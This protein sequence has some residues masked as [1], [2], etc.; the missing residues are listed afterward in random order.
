MKNRSKKVRTEPSAL[1]NNGGFITAAASLGSILAGL[2]V[3][4][5]IT[6]VVSF[7]SDTISLK[8]GLEG[9]K[10]IFFG[11]F[12]TGRDA[13]GELSFGF[14]PVN[15]GNL[16]F[17][18]TPVIMTGLSV[19][20]SFRAGLFNI[21]APGQYLMGTAATLFVALSLP[22]EAV[23]S[24]LIWLLSFLSGMLAG[25][26]WGAIPGLLKARLNI[27]EVLSG[28]MT[29]WIAANLVTWFFENSSLR[30]S[31]Q[32]G[33]IGYVMPTSLNGV[34]TSKIGLDKL[35]P[36]SQVNGGIIVALLFAFI[37]YTMLYK[38][39]SGY[40]M[41]A[42][43][44]NRFAAEYAGMK[45]K[46]VTVLSMAAAGALS[47]GGA[48]LYYLSGNTEFF[49]STY[50]SLPQEGFNGIPIAL[51]AVNN[52][53]AV[54]FTGLFMSGLNIAG[55]QLKNLTAYNE[56]ITD[57]IIAVIVYLSAF[58]LV[59]KYFISIRAKGKT[60]VEIAAEQGTT[61]AQTDAGD[62]GEIRLETHEAK[63][64]NPDT[65]KTGREEE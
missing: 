25:A 5:I 19:A 7:V 31:V 32:P 47:A 52:P 60:A 49:H 39:T 35:F 65:E 18:A 53:I 14:N 37:V 34:A 1:L 45:N 21:G 44:N 8:G 24:I 36:G 12:S 51:L 64:I 26:L 3:G 61:T 28:I 54:V 22:S 2:A 30:N 27:N 43:G 20:L 13:S 9:L 17:R 57:I 40:V 46:R 38:T 6:L 59:I 4:G 62:D 16:L 23:P 55:Q 41:K 58:S 29:N 50:Q 10:L 33:K 15:I 11:L 63:S 42:C 56:H 48:A